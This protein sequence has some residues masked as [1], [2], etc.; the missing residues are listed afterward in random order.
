MRGG[1]LS[2]DSRQMV[3]CLL[4]LVSSFEFPAWLPAPGWVSMSFL[5]QTQA[6]SMLGKSAHPRSP[7]QPHRQPHSVG[8]HGLTFIHRQ[9]G[10]DGPLL[11]GDTPGSG[12]S[13]EVMVSSVYNGGQPGRGPPQSPSLWPASSASFSRSSGLKTS[14]SLPVR[15]A[16]PN[17]HQGAWGWGPGPRLVSGLEGGAGDRGGASP[18]TSLL[19]VANRGAHGGRAWVSGSGGQA[20]HPVQVRLALHLFFLHLEG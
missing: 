13:R 15:R 8:F 1:G 19:H 2:K 4:T 17:W 20:A 18:S 9:K 16:V 5:L 14:V 11:T 7:S 6:Q 12:S 10:R 3:T